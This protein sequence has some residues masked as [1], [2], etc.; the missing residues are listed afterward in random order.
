MD[1][2]A[3]VEVCQL[4]PE[5]AQ[6]LKVVDAVQEVAAHCEGAFFVGSRGDGTQ[7]ERQAPAE[8]WAATFAA[9]SPL[10]FRFDG[11]SKQWHRP[12]S[13]MHYPTVLA[14]MNVTH[15]LHITAR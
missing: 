9:G 12:G 5:A 6:Q 1:L 8:N 11:C 15:H 2:H 14:A 7:P 13:R 10:A 4:A 3:A